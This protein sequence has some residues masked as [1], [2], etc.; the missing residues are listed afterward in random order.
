MNNHLQYLHI[1]HPLVLES[2]EK[3]ERFTIAYQA[4]GQLNA[5]KS[6]VVWVCHAFTGNAQP[7][8]WW[9]ELIGEG[10]LFDPAQHYI[11]CANMVG[12]C[13]GS[14]G[15]DHINPATGQPYGLA[16]PLVTT[17]DMAAA[18]DLLRQ[19]LG[20]RAIWLGIGGSMG[21][22][23]LVEW[24][25]LQP[26]LFQHL[27][28]LATNARHS[29]WGIAFNEAQRMALQSDPTLGTQAP[30][31]GRKGIEAARAVAMLSYRHYQAYHQTQA[32]AEQDKISDF[33]AGSYQ[34]YQGYKLWQRFSPLAYWS[35]SKSM[36]SH[37]IA[38]KRGSVADAL[39]HIQAR[40]L[41]IGIESDVLFP[42][43]EQAELAAHIPQAHL[44]VISSPYG[45]DGFLT[46]S[47]KITRLIERF[48]GG[49]LQPK[50]SAPLL[51]SSKSSFNPYVLPGS[52]AF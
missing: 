31:A 23:Q 18:H 11:V 27:C 45:H 1:D 34:Q 13:Y 22:Q 6:N 25:I 29:P 38:R 41:V 14:T 51:R 8:A 24:A 52:E 37:N 30:E 50:Q 20:L 46:E 2:G 35:L 49:T 32:E 15:P 43:S 17:R 39:A 48:L 44:E 42:P 21:G 26:T 47:D 16:F 3:L 10:R 40:T 5:D 12:S 36:D 7:Q 9:G 33:K 19:H 4:W 28:L